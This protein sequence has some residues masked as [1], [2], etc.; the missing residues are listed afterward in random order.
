MEINLALSVDSVTLIQHLK[1][2][3]TELNYD[4]IRVY[5]YDKPILNTP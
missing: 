2:K 4:F 5:K 3:N 1:N